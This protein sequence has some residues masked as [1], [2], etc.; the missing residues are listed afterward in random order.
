MLLRL[1]AAYIL[2]SD[3]YITTS[4]SLAY[5][6]RFSFNRQLKISASNE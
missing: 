3:L 6:N 4:L 2:P 1:S 5:N